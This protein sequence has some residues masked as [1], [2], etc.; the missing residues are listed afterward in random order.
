MKVLVTG[1]TGFVGSH[2][3]E[4][5]RREGHAVRA[6]AR[7]R[8][9]TEAL[10][11]PDVEWVPGDL[12]DAAALREAVRGVTV[13]YH[14]A[15][16]IAARSD[17]EYFAVNRDATERLL[18]AASEAD[19]STR[20]VLVSSLAAAGPSRRGQPLGE[21][22]EPRPVT[23]YGRS[24]LAGEQV[25]RQGSLP[26]TIIRPPAVYGPR[27]REMFRLFRAA[28]LGVAPLPGDGSQEL[29]LVYGPDLAE[30]IARAG[31]ADAAVGRTYFAAHPETLTAA[32]VART[33]AAASGKRVRLLRI[34][35]PVARGVL[36]ITGAVARLADRATVLNPDKANEF[37]QP[38]W[39]CRPDAIERDLGWRA[40]HDLEAG[41]RATVE[42]Y[43]AHGWL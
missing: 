37:L 12:A 13:V 6:L 24:K 15:G 9:R 4:V 20:F 34:P 33:I 38:A 3:N 11:R 7:S 21:D 36:Q 35:A 42:W 30:A 29:S 27:D 2:L 31:I 19:A 23:A 22:A 8:A 17:L 14:V 10:G 40:A 25:V 5:L 16:L 18:R 32:D 43:R 41:A 26:W 28:T 1:G 39:T